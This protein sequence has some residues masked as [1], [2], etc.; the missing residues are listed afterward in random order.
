MQRSLTE[1]QQALD[2]QLTEF[3]NKQNALVQNLNQQIDSYSS[4]SQAQS[5]DLV[6][7]NT[8]LGELSSAF[9]ASKG[10]M[11]T[12]LAT[13][14]RGLTATESSGRRIPNGNPCS[15]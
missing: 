6:A 5:A 4:A 7:T 11:A 9:N 3:L 13:L 8:K 14:S 12:E 15:E 2:D 10:T 1:H